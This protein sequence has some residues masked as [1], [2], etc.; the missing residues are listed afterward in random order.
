MW[1]QLSLVAY[2]T[3]KLLK[4]TTH[5]LSDW[6]FICLLKPAL[7]QF[8]WGTQYESCKEKVSLLCC[9]TLSPW[10]RVGDINLSL[11]PS[12]V[13][14]SLWCQPKGEDGPGQR[15]WMRGGQRG[16]WEEKGPLTTETLLLGSPP[17]PCGWHPWTADQMAAALTQ[18]RRSN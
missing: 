2:F 14:G 11:I 7:L 10:H 5:N 18:Q 3:T 4:T 1:P 13:K 15:Y 9:Y 17:Q 16:G 8:I 12:S 6:H